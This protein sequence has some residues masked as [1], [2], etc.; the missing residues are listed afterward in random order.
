MDITFFHSFSDCTD[1]EMAGL[2]KKFDSC[3]NP[4]EDLSA[5]G[6]LCQPLDHHHPKPSGKMPHQ[7]SIEALDGVEL[8]SVLGSTLVVDANVAVVAVAVQQ[9]AWKK[10]FSINH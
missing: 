8:A 1:V 6:R 4:T 2:L 3:R 7:V 9:T 10:S 5:I